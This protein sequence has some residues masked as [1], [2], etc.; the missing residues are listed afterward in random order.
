MANLY[1]RNL[2]NYFFL[3]EGWS[4]V[5]ALPEEQF[6]RG[7]LVMQSTKPPPGKKARQII[8]AH[9]PILLFAPILIVSLDS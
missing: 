6:A 9:I 4:L 7:D 2:P 8:E 1:R 3:E 5:L